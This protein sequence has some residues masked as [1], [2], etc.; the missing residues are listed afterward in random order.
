MTH[1]VTR[2]LRYR[3]QRSNRRGGWRRIQPTMPW[4]GTLLRNNLKTNHICSK[5]MGGGE[6]E[7]E[8]EKH[9]MADRANDS[10]I[11]SCNDKLAH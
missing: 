8:A 2:T 10:R 6:Y 4:S 5:G 1:A 3:G 7:Q 11:L 9:S